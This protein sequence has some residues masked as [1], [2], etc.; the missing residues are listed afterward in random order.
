VT[1]A[2]S[3][4]TRLAGVTGWP[5]GHSLSPV[6]HNAAY[7]AMRLDWVYVPLPVEDADDLPRLFS[8]LKVLP[9]VGMNVTMP[10][11]EAAMDLCDE[12]AM[13]AQLAGAVNCVANVDGKL[14][15]YNTDGRGFLEALATEVGFEPEGKRVA[16]IGAG[17][18][19]GGALVALVLAKAARVTVLNRSV[20]KAERL[21]SRLEGRTRDTVVEAGPLDEE[22]AGVVEAADLIVNAT[23][24]GMGPDDAS[25]VPEAWLREGQI[26][27]DMIYRPEVTPLMAAAVRRGGKAVGGLGM[28]VAQGA[29][30]IEIWNGDSQT[31]APRDVMRAAAEASLAEA[32]RKADR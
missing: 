24:I 10:Y 6:M 18:A 14:I 9:F 22:A 7:R 16:V 26:A 21:V 15:G 27:A 20:D 1:D 17:G 3:G 4:R 5:I 8:A 11:K 25:P 32:S 2:I 30:S 23:P 19:A 28:L 12:V 13:Y 29:T 31:P